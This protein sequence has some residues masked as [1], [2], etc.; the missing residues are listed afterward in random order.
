MNLELLDAVLN[1]EPFEPG[2]ITTTKQ[3]LKKIIFIETWEQKPGFVYAG[4]PEGEEALKQIRQLKKL[5]ETYLES[6]KA[7]R[8]KLVAQIRSTI[9]SIQELSELIEQINQEEYPEGSFPE[10]LWPMLNLAASA[11]Y[12]DIDTLGKS[13]IIY[14]KT[15]QILCEV[16]FQSE[17]QIKRFHEEAGE[18]NVLEFFKEKCKIPVANVH[19]SRDGK[20]QQRL[21]AVYL[22]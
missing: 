3:A 19:V 13:V 2:L 22:E 6:T 8:R 14:D 18:G 21:Q 10:A 7:Q 1:M 20:I 17:N 11:E 16:T 15:G 4:A 5:L 12:K 9:K